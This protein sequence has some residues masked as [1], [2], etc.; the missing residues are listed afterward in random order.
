MLC[1]IN[2]LDCRSTFYCGI[3]IRVGTNRGLVAGRFKYTE[4]Q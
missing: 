2:G 1:N 3:L 4:F